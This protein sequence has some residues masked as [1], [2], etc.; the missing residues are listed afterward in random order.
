MDDESTLTA[1]E[2]A[3]AVAAR[4]TYLATVKQRADEYKASKNAAP[5]AAAPSK[6]G[7]NF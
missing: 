3:E 1:N 2:V 6:T 4:E 7:F 5:A